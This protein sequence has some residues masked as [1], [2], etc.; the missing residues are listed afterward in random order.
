MGAGAVNG[1]FGAQA[2]GGDHVADLADDVVSQQASAVVFE[3]GIDDAVEGHDDAKRDQNLRAIE[4]AAQ[5]IDSGLGCEC[6]HEDRT[7]E[8]GF[9]ISVRQP[10]V[11][12]RDGSV[13]DKASQDE[14]SGGRRAIDGEVS[15]VLVKG[16]TACGLAMPYY[17]GQQ[18]QPA[19]DVHQQIAQPGGE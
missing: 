18:R 16:P 10:S 9:A 5:R 12:W 8:S 15:E 13:E 11:E 2:D 17:A 14:P 4:T 3:H 19:G 7:V 6:A 1:E